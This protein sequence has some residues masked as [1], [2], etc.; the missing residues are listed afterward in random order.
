MK[1]DDMLKKISKELYKELEKLGLI[2][3]TK[4]NSNCITAGITKK[5]K[6]KKKYICE[7]VLRRYDKIMQEK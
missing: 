4:N 2:D 3:L 1:A 6:R 7:A 5:S